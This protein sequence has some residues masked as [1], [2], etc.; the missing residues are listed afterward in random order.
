MLNF[1]RN[2]NRI[3]PARIKREDFFLRLKDKNVLIVHDFVNSH[4]VAGKNGMMKEQ[5]MLK[6]A[7][8]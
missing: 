3:H 4:S 7:K 6:N 1:R 8:T 2:I 5:R